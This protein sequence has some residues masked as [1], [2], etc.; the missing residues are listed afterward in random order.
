MFEVLS[1]QWL[2]GYALHLNFAVVKFECIFT[3]FKDALNFNQGE[4]KGSI[5]G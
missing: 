3:H 1:K 2:Q 5:W 4:K